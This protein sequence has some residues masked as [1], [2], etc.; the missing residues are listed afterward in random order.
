M[1][2]IF[3]YK[4]VRLNFVGDIFREALSLEWIKNHEVWD[5][6]IEDRNLT[7]HTYKEQIMKVVEEIERAS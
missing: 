7:S 1:R 6:M 3:V 4:N 2:S 5:K